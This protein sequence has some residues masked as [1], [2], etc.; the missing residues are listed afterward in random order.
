MSS[1]SAD[2]HSQAADTRPLLGRTAVV[3]RLPGWGGAV[4]AVACY[5]VSLTPSLLPRPWWLQAVVAAITATIGYA[6]GALV[7]WAV[8]A[9][10]FRPSRRV[11]LW[12]WVALGV[13]G[14][15][16]TVAVTVRSV[17]WQDGLRQLMDMDP[18]V[19]WWQ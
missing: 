2:R 6:V 13:L 8:R 3:R 5:C 15:A 11:V 10:G 19:V 18:H 9:F 1:E 14:V 7:G 12:A 16:A 4:G 17:A